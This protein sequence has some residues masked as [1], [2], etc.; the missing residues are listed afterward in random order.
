M[1]E[2][3]SSVLLAALLVTS[4]ARAASLPAV[5]AELDEGRVEA[6]AGFVAPRASVVRDE[7]DAPSAAA[8]ALE[9]PLLAPASV[10]RAWLAT[11]VDAAAYD[12]LSFWIRGTG[13]PGHVEL[14]LSPAPAEGAEVV[15]VSRVLMSNPLWHRVFLPFS[16]FYDPTSPAVAIRR[17]DPAQA[18][19][20]RIG[21][22]MTGPTSEARSLAVDALGLSTRAEVEGSLGW[23]TYMPPSHGFPP[24]LDRFD[25]ALAWK[26]EGSAR[27]GLVP[28]E[29][30]PHEG[31]RRG[32]L[33]ELPDLDAR[34]W[35]ELD[36]EPLPYYEGFAFWI[37]G[38]G[39]DRTIDVTLADSEA[40]EPYVFTILV[41]GK[42]WK[43][44]FAGFENF[45][46]GREAFEAGDAK[47]A[48]L[49]LRLRGEQQLP[50]RVQLGPMRLGYEK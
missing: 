5:V 48:I 27:A 38:D 7:R 12:G 2:R 36:V 23:P 11:G 13:K 29:A 43:L 15:F 39:V 6:A 20:V 45:K 18:G 24:Y 9:V 4:L 25:G 26:G 35:R 14:V 37:R 34:V 32:L 31:F 33:V 10:M 47:R 19:K 42:E 21:L 3:R 8:T 50:A 28:L 1:S 41:R 40:V 30:F 16:E 44:V 49:G 22:Q 17:F 46:H